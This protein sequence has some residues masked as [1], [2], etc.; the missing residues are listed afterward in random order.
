MPNW[1]ANRVTICGDAEEVTRF[2]EAVRKEDNPFSLDA[3]LPMPTALLGIITGWR[4]I[5]G[6]KVKIWREVNGKSIEVPDEESR[7]LLAQHGADNWYDWCAKNWGTKWDTEG[8]DVKVEELSDDMVLYHFDTAWGPPEEICVIL[9]ERFP[10][11]SIEWF[12]DEP[13]NQSAG[14]L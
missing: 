2:R 4:E 11:L 1:C 14:Y 12:Y 9:R 6:K 10:S 7:A 13:G 5:D 3:I 8:P